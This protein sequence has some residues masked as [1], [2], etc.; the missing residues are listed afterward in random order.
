MVLAMEVDGFAVLR[1]FVGHPPGKGES[2]D[3]FGVMCC[4]VGRFCR[5]VRRSEQANSQTAPH[6]AT[7]PYH[8]SLSPRRIW[9]TIGSLNGSPPG[10]TARD[11]SPSNSATAAGV[12]G[13]KAVECRGSVA[14]EGDTVR[15]RGTTNHASACANNNMGTNLP[16]PVSGEA[17]NTRSGTDSIGTL[18]MNSPASDNAKRLS[19]SA[20]S[21]LPPVENAPLRDPNPVPKDK[22]G[23]NGSVNGSG[24]ALS[25]GSGSGGGRKRRE[26]HG[27]SSE[28]RS[29]SSSRKSK[30]ADSTG[31]QARRNKKD[32][33]AEDRVG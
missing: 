29:S 30:A 21:A 20:R 1:G 5:K 32:E 18:V 8:R 4:A 13:G 23:S 33:T 17:V 16:R 14:T 11:S 26:G 12:S 6:A 9:R 27:V 28:R 25:A 3:L 19:N 22:R 24:Q 7:A 31:D 10:T 2:R 15:S